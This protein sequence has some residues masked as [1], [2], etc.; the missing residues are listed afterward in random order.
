MGAEG[1][2]RQ[3][4][5][6]GAGRREARGAGQRA[7]GRAGGGGAQERAEPKRCA[8]GERAGGMLTTGP[9]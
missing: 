1:A 2:P 6:G 7:P 4:R 9:S 3:V 8:G 5:R